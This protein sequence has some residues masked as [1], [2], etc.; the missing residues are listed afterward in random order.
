MLDH[1]AR[2][3]RDGAGHDVGAP[4][5]RPTTCGVA[6]RAVQARR[7]EPRRRGHHLALHRAWNTTTAANGTHTLTAVARDAAGQHDAPRRRS[8]RHGEQRRRRPGHRDHGADGRRRPSP[9]RRRSPP[10]RPTTCGVAGVQFKLDGVEPRRRG[11]GLAVLARLG[12]GRARRTAPHTLTAVVARHARQHDHHG[13]R[14]RHRLERRRSAR[15]HAAR[16]HRRRA[17]HRL[18][19][20]R[21]G[22]GVQDDRPRRGRADDDEALSRRRRR[23]RRRSSSASTPTARAIPAR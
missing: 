15:R 7:R 9:A 12:H 14:H 1:G 21:P 20:R 8:T 2:R 23:P 3:R 10:P 17:E 19:R 13:E 4:R 6:G 18:Q 16:Q 22:R 5:P 11:H